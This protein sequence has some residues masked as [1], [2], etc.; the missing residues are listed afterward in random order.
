VGKRWDD[1][2]SIAPRAS[3][4]FM[5]ERTQPKAENREPL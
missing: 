4:N 2:F 5:S 1:P 3:E